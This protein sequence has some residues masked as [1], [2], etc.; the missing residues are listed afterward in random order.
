MKFGAF[1][2]MLPEYPPEEALRVL[3]EVGF[4]GV[5]WRIADGVPSRK[6][7]NY[8]RA[9]RYWSYNRCTYNI[10]DIDRTAPGIKRMCENAGLEIC[11]LAAYRTPNAVVEIER[12]FKAAVILDCRQVRIAMPGYDGKENYRDLWARTVDQF[13]H[14]VNL[15][16]TYGVRILLETHHMTIIPSASAAY[17]FVSNFDAR[18]VGIILDPGNMVFEGHE[19]YQMAIELLNEYLAHVHVKNAQ[20]RCVETRENGVKVWKPDWTALRAGQADIA[21]LIQ[22][23]RDKNYAGYVCL[24]DFSDETE[25]VDKLREGLGFLR[26]LRSRR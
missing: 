25:T 17:R 16:D 23:L 22:I 6:P 19:N 4:D 7:E 1:T 10:E 21:N 9:N 18:R 2:V 11:G 26:Q 3:K 24:E 14:I 5:E 8:T 20:W 12:A 15:S 13:A